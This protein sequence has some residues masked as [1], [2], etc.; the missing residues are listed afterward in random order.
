VL[1]A[2]NTLSHLHYDREP[3]LIEDMNKEVIFNNNQYQWDMRI[4]E[5]MRKGK[6]DKLMSILPEFMEKTAA[7]VK[8]GGLTWMLAAMG[9]PTIPAQVHGYWTVIGT[10]NAVVEWDLTSSMMQ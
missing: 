9:F 5:L 1:A 6:T 3:E 10:G 7:E 2:S 4:L 8:S